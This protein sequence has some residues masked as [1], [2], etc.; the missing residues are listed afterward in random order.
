VRQ[1]WDCQNPSLRIIINA[2]RL[3]DKKLG[4]RCVSMKRYSSLYASLVFWEHYSMAIEETLVFITE[5]FN[6]QLLP[7]TL[8]T[9]VR[10]DHELRMIRGISM[11]KGRLECN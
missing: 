2:R 11:E 3:N 6:M 5:H 10:P 9:Q 1:F 8:H 7:N 4:D